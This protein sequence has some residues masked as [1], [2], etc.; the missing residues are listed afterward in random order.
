MKKPTSRKSSPA[1]H[2]AAL[3][4]FAIASLPLYAQSQA[5][6][7]SQLPV[8]TPSPQ[9]QPALTFEVASIHPHPF[10]GDEPSNRRILPGGRFV[11]TATTVRTLLRIATGNDDISGAPKW[12]D[13]EKFDIT[14]TTVNRAD[15]KTPE[16]FQQII[17]SLLEDRFH[18]KFHCVQQEGSVF[19]LELERPGKLGP[20]LKPSAPDAQ[21]NM[22]MNSS[23]SKAAMKV[24]NLSMAYVAA[25]LRRQSGR[26]VEDHTNLKGN[27][28]FE[29]TWAPDESPDSNDPSLF[30]VLKEQ[31]GL[32]LKPAKGP[33][34][35][36]VIDQITEA[37]AN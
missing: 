32:K 7:G 18:L 19:S 1:I 28:D 27:F 10:T 36:F 29:I 14:A 20:A 24:S 12:I 11:A 33:I 34:Q 4:A 8:T 31:L 3:F 15:I 9:T 16:Q 30:T 2:C 35:I 25:A 17:L 21:P 22:S 5:A 23:G 37:S 26:P 13:D 6:C